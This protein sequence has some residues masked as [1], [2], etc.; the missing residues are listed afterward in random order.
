MTDQNFVT[1]AEIRAAWLEYV[2]KNPS[3]FRWGAGRGSKE[4]LV[5][6]RRQIEWQ[7]RADKPACTFKVAWESEN[8][9]W[10]LYAFGKRGI[11][12]RELVTTNIGKPS[13]V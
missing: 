6:P 13:F 1:I 11:T 9:R 12:A 5:A 10:I 2:S 3:V 8:K 7:N 4:G